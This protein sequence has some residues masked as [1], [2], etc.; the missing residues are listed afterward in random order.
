MK[1]FWTMIRYALVFGA[2]LVAVACG[3]DDD[4]SAD[5]D[6]HNDDDVQHDDDTV[7]DDDGGDNDVI[8]DDDSAD[9][10]ADDD[11]APTTVL[12]AI[13]EV[14]GVVTSFVQDNLGWAERPL[15][16]PE[17]FTS[18]YYLGPTA[19]LDGE[20]GYAVWNLYDPPYYAGVEWLEFSRTDGWQ[21]APSRNSL[22]WTVDYLALHEAN[23]PLAAAYVNIAWDFPAGVQLLLQYDSWF[24]R[25]LIA[26]E[27]WTV[28]AMAFP[29]PEEGLVAT[30]GYYSLDGTLLRYDHGEWQDIGLPLG[31]TTGYIHSLALIDMNNG[32]AL[33][34]AGEAG[35]KMLVL[36]DGVWSEIAAPAGCEEVVPNHVQTSADYAIGW[37]AADDPENRFWEFR[38]GQW[39]CR[40]VEAESATVYLRHASLWPDGRVFLAAVLG[41][42]P[43]ETRIYEV[44]ATGF[45]IV[46]PPSSLSDL[47][48]TQP[49][50]APG[51]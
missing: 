33:W 9:D 39:A 29:S 49:I 1:F 47:Y 21:R 19:F 24:P 48:E 17:L 8:G 51:N 23:A 2:S 16:E 44:T 36:A 27:D 41:D 50:R 20:M 37:R 43:T 26:S 12:L 6:L 15:P 7:A 38:D 18:S 13:G 3:D 11:T 22:H 14:D 25:L 31:L 28:S 32:V 42:P 35:K 10:D 34:S 4:N 46:A 40:A 5:D 30:A 45:T